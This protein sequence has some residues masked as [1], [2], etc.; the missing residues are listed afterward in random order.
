MVEV[1]GATVNAGDTV[2]TDVGRSGNNITIKFT[3]SVSDGSY[4]ALLNNVA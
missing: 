2:Y 3:G 4:Q 1:L